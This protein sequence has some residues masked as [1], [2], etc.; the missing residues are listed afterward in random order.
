MCIYFFFVAFIQA[1]EFLLEETGRLEVVFIVAWVSDIIQTAGNSMSRTRARGG[2]DERKAGKADFSGGSRDTFEFREVRGNG[3][4][5]E[6][7]LEEV[8]FIEEEDH[9]R[10]D[11]PLGIADLFENHQRFSHIIL[12]INKIEI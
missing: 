7:G 3:G 5:A 12:H 9:G 2:I 4:V 11:E 1:D 8:D 10:F 6:L